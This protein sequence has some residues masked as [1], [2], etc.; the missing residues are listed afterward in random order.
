REIQ[1]FQNHTQ[2]MVNAELHARSGFVAVSSLYSFIISLMR[3]GALV[4]SVAAIQ[5]GALNAGLVYI[6]LTYTFNLI[7]E[8]WNFNDII[9][10]HHQMTGDTG[11]LY[12]IMQQPQDVIDT[13]DNEI[14]VKEGLVQVDKVN[15]SHADDKTTL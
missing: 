4:A 12:K 7:E 10:D 14:S 2:N 11:E 8:I 1:S 5:Y 9:R 15:F 13:S 3:I 6:C